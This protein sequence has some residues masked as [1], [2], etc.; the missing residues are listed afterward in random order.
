MRLV[1]TETHFRC[2]GREKTE[3]TILWRTQQGRRI[4]TCRACRNALVARRRKERPLSHAMQTLRGRHQRAKQQAI[5]KNDDL[6]LCH[7][8]AKIKK[9]FGSSENRVSRVILAALYE[10]YTLGQQRGK[11]DTPAGYWGRLPK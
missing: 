2:C 9:A 5:P 3:A 6:R 7:L 10:A 11:A 1:S 8:L 4:P